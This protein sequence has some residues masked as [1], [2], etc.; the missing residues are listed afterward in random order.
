M[1]NVDPPMLIG[2]AFLIGSAA[3][4][5]APLVDL[6][7]LDFL[8]GT[9]KCKASVPRAL[10]APMDSLTSTFGYEMNGTWL[11]ETNSWANGSVDQELISYDRERKMFTL[12]RLSS[13]DHLRVV[14]FHS[15]LVDQGSVE[16][17]S[18]YPDGVLSE[19][20]YVESPLKYA[21]LVRWTLAPDDVSLID[22]AKE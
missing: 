11:R 3:T 17:R 6:S 4:K 14:V 18:V 5:S 9:W 22:C 1:R 19:T 13:D 12:V 16:F 2:L 10:S 21:K 20:L 15:T 8:A 7:S